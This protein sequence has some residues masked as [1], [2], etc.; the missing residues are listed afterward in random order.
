LKKL[1]WK[2][3]GAS[4]CVTRL[5]RLRSGAH[6]PTARRVP[7]GTLRRALVRPQPSAGRQRSPPPSV[8]KSIQLSNNKRAGL[9]FRQGNRPAPSI[10]LKLCSRFWEREAAPAF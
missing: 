10:L 6:F 7:A 5:R 4:E 2:K 9:W 3:K 1:L 8:Q